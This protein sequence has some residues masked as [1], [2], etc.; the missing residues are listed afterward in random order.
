MTY[1]QAKLEAPP[2]PLTPDQLAARWQQSFPE[3]LG[4]AVECE[5]GESLYGVNDEA[6][7]RVGAI[8]HLLDPETRD[9]ENRERE[10]RLAA[11]TPLE[12]QVREDVQAMIREELRHRA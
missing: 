3:A 2:E 1:T 6:L 8:P 12:R 5:S 7:A 4:P 11:L 10:Q 9:R